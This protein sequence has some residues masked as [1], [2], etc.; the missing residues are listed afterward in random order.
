MKRREH[1]LT[2]V[3]FVVVA[4]A[5]F[6]VL[7]GTIELARLFYTYAVLAESM[8]RAARVAA[9][10][11]PGSPAI[12][13]AARDLDDAIDGF[14]P[15]INMQVQYLDANGFPTLP[16]GGGYGNIS[17]VR[18]RVV[19]DDFGHYDITLNIPFVDRFG[20]LRVR[21]PDFAVTLP[22]ESL[23]VSPTSATF[24]GFGFF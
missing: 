23:G 22:R 5:T 13:R 8:R 7:F 15:F 19:G 17:Y 24:C 21:S 12:Q 1:G 16:F 20:W 11:P 18:A 10:C 2:S 4:T 3:E 9:V 14:N 6:L